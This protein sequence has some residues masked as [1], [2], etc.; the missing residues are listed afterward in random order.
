MFCDFRHGGYRIVGDIICD[1]DDMHRNKG[2]KEHITKQKGDGENLR[3]ILMGFEQAD[4]YKTQI[5]RNCVRVICPPSRKNA[6]DFDE[7][8]MCAVALGKRQFALEVLPASVL[9]LTLDRSHVFAEIE[10][11][12]KKWRLW[13]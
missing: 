13:K 4:D 8:V 3:M 10:P 11:K 12:K 5:I 2:I 6:L 9:N 7:V 1:I